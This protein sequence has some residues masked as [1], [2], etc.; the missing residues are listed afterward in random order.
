M[1]TYNTQ[2]MMHDIYLALYGLKLN[3]VHNKR[4]ISLTPDTLYQRFIELSSLIPP[5]T[6]SWSSSLVTLFYNALSVE[7]QEAIRLDGYTLPNNSTLAT[8]FSQTS[9]LKVLQEK[10]VVA[11]KLLCEE[12]QRI[13]SIQILFR[14][15]QSESTTCILRLNQLFA[16]IILL[17]HNLDHHAL[18]LKERTTSSTPGIQL[19]IML[20]G[21]VM[22]LAVV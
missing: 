8:L 13:L 17:I 14:L 16:P 4:I 19:P 22:G 12:K 20:V 9:T 2:R 11:H 1:K 7:L 5:N 6:T 10:A 3:F 21:S 18:L 15:A